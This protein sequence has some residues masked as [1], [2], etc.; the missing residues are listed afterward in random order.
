MIF[1]F[2][3][4]I[5][6]SSAET[7]IFDYTR[8]NLVAV[9]AGIADIQTGT[10][11]I[12]H[13][14]EMEKYGEVL[15]QI[16][17]R[18]LQHINQSH[19][20]FPYLSREINTIRNNLH[21][22]ELKQRIPRSINAIGTAWKWLAGSPDHDD[23][24]IVKDK[25]NQILK[26][27]NN[28]VIINK[29]T[30]EKIKEIQTVT[31]EIIK[32]VKTNG[33]IDNELFLNYKY[34]L[35]VLEEETRN[36]EYAINWAKANVVNA[37]I[38]ANEEIK[39]IDKILARNDIPFM[40]IDEALEFSSVK[41]AKNNNTILYILS[42]PLSEEEK[43]TKL[44][45]KPVKKGNVAVKVPYENVLKCN[46]KLFGII[47][48]CRTVNDISLCKIHNIIDLSNDNCIPNLLN[49]RKADC[50][51]IN[52]QHIPTVEELAPG[53]LFLNQFKGTVT[54]N[55]ETTIIQG[56]FL[57]RFHN[58]SLSIEGRKYSYQELSTFHPIPALLQPT[59]HEDKIEEILSLEMIK[60]LQLNNTEL[61]NGLDNE[62][63]IN[64]IT[65]WSFGSLVVVII[66]YGLIKV[67]VKKRGKIEI[68]TIFKTGNKPE[69]AQQEVEPM[70]FQPGQLGEI[71]HQ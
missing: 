31:N 2:R 10:F 69:G 9:D 49:S 7:Q 18:I 66:L 57:I 22:L 20:L 8:S 62:N 50:I 48:K 36:I 38:L 17:E 3:V 59:E 63:K 25:T 12:V 34:K 56:T 29:L 15:E 26:N 27:T 47:N 16:E 28:Q 40:N 4:L 23:F 30:S 46:K 33:E 11:K 45:L 32:I 24:Q 13:V 37:H 55:N 14:F 64:L 35:D 6:A 71:L 19:I 42:I 44:I 67:I 58:A 68:H 21:R 43:C 41:I 60:E 39:I 1:H 54:I 65:N 5:V 52:N 70:P 51:N 53:L 61:I